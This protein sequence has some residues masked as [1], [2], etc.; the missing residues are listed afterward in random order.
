VRIHVLVRGRIGP[1]WEDVDRVFTMP[2]GTTLAALLDREAREGVPLR[3]LIERSPHLPHTM[4][5]NGERCPL[6]ENL[7]RALADG[8][9]LYL[10]GPIAGG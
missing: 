7:E 8:D 2:P 1:S 4:M 3:A 9:E 10:L 5:L 6:R